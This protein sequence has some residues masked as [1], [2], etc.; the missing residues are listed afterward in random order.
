[1]VVYYACVSVVRQEFHKR[2]VSLLVLAHSVYKLDYALC[3]LSRMT[4]QYA[5]L[6]SIGRRNQSPFFKIM[7]F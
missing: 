2:D 5:D 3:P 7:L 6:Q 1:M 4:G